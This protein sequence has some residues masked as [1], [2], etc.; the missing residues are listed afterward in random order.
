M[1]F[2]VQLANDIRDIDIRSFKYSQFMYY[3]LGP[4]PNAARILILLVK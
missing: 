3:L 1:I 4:Y 2:I